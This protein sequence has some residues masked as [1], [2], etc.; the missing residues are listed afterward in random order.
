M[1]AREFKAAMAAVDR[2]KALVED[3]EMARVKIRLLEQPVM[4][5][6]L[7][8]FRKKRETDAEFQFDKDET[9]AVYQALGKLKAEHQKAARDLEQSVKEAMKP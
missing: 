1:N 7:F 2:H 6:G 4:R 9:F 8:G 3:A 5:K